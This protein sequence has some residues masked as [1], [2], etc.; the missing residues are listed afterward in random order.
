MGMEETPPSF[1]VGRENRTRER[2]SPSVTTIAIGIVRSLLS[3][4]A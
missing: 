4:D 1:A 3:L 2:I